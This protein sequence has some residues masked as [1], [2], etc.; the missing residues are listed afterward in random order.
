[1]FSTLYGTYF[2]FQMHF[3]MSSAI[4]FNLDKSKILLSG[5]GLKISWKEIAHLVK[6]T[7]SY[8]N[9]VKHSIHW[10]HALEKGGLLHLSDTSYQARH[11]INSFLT[12]DHTRSFCGQCWSR[13]DCTFCA[14]GSLINTVHIFIL[15][16]H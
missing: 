1:M 12:D 10:T 16:Y 13:S 5:N 14:V 4:C 7:I 6:M 8:T 11:L 9:Y 15:D 3:E 2:I